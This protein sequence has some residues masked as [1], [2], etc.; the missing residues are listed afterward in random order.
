MQNR[1]K[2]Q[3][4]LVP[5][6]KHIYVKKLKIKWYNTFTYWLNDSIN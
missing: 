3:T 1:L 2:N 6:L 5:N 4:I